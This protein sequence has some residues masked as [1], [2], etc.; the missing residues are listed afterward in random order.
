MDDDPRVHHSIAVILTDSGMN[1]GDLRSRQ[2]PWHYCEK[3]LVAER[4]VLLLNPS[5]HFHKSLADWGDGL[6]EQ[7][8]LP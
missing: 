1:Q 6:L 7:G 4:F 5:R 3:Q 2:R 8:A